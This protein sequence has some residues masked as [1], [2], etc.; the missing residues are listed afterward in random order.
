MK[1]M[2][3]EPDY[4]EDAQGTRHLVAGLVEVDAEGKLIA[5]VG[6]P[7]A[8]QG[9]ETALEGTPGAVSLPEP[10]A[11]SQEQEQVAPVA[12]AMAG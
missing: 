9:S 6:E 11:P 3:H 8:A 2:L 10:P 4:L 12:P 7:V 1:L 5:P